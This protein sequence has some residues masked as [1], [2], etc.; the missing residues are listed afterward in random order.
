VA[1]L[2]GF[3]A[4]IAADAAGNLYVADASLEIIQKISPSGQM[5]TLAGSSGLA[6]AVDGTGA[7]ARL[8]QPG[9]I[10]ASAA[11]F[12]TV[13]DT[14]NATIRT[15]LADGTVMT[16]AGSPT[17]HGHL[18][19]VGTAATFAS[20][21]G[22]AQDAGGTLYVADAMNHAIRKITA[23]G[24]VT[25]LAGSAGNSGSADGTG[26]AARFNYP[27]GVAVDA[28]GNVYV[29]DTTNNL[30]RK[31][32]PA[33]VV[34]TLAGV[35]G[36]SG[37]QDGTGSGALFNQPGGLAV[38]GAGNLYLNDTGNSTVRRITPAGVVTTIVGLPGIAGFKDGT[39]TDAWLNQPKAVA[40]DSGGNLFIADTGNAAIRKVTT[41]GV[42]T[43]LDL[44]PAPASGSSGSTGSTGTTTPSAPSG[45]SSSGGGGGGGGALG[46]WF[47][48]ALG[49]L[50]L[51]RWRMR[52]K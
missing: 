48:S 22:I 5:S 8:N 40:L 1:A 4:G 25:T 42:S 39:G 20:P 41:A 31:I 50:G 45:T 35:A 43:T 37:A 33:G 13:A 26:A 49:L 2:L 9:G 14:A 30:L 34:T 24:V 23:S 47:G 27:T 51:L 3:P 19:G 12:L 52:S 32:S 29:A 46:A 38:D 17:N 15:I 6:G 21:I 44:T 7:T 36:V 18:D 16:L 10:T 28:S 11:G